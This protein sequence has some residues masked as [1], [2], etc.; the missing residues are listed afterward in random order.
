ML[1]APNDARRCGAGLAIRF[2]LLALPRRSLRV[3]R[4][5]G[6][7]R[8]CRCGRVAHVERGDLAAEQ[9]VDPVE[10]G[11]AHQRAGRFLLALRQREHLAGLEG[12]VP[13]AVAD[14]FGLA[15]L[16]LQ[17]RRGVEQ[18]AQRH[19]LLPARRGRRSQH[20]LGVG[21]RTTG[22]SSWPVGSISTSRSG[23][24]AA[25]RAAR[26][27]RCRPRSCRAAGAR[28]ARPRTHG[29]SISEPRSACEIDQRHRPVASRRAPARR[30]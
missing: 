7:A 27:R 22:S 2:L 23:L 12:Q 16:R 13:A 1:T 11:E 4:S 17:R 14:P 5:R 20:A 8:A 9:A 25:P 24:L 6:R 26:A 28:R 3:G 21:R 19:D 15:D 29:S 30:P 10:P 18:R